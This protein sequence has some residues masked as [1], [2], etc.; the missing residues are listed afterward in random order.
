MDPKTGSYAG[1]ISFPL[2]KCVCSNSEDCSGVRVT[3]GLGLEAGLP[4]K[5]QDNPTLDES[6]FPIAGGIQAEAG[7]VWHQELRVL[8]SSWTG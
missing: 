5:A 3:C 7:Q 6:E 1:S 4:G 8:D 2:R